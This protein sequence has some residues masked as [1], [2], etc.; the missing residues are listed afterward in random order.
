MITSIKGG[1]RARINSDNTLM[2]TES[3]CY[4]DKE[5][6]DESS[7]Q[8]VDEECKSEDEMCVR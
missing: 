7:F 1:A 3:S 2:L 5:Q 4:G 6:P 8:Q